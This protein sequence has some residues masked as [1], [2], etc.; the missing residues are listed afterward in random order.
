MVYTTELREH[1]PPIF[2]QKRKPPR[3]RNSMKKGKKAKWR[4]LFDS[5]LRSKASSVLK[6]TPPTFTKSIFK[7]S[8][9]TQLSTN[10]IENLKSQSI[11]SISNIKSI[12][13]I[14]NSQRLSYENSQFLRKESFHLPSIKNTFKLFPNEKTEIFLSGNKKKILPRQEYYKLEKF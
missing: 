8:R 7:T 1:L 9:L 5:E 2:G 10:L 6:S 4:I 13:S 3:K 12:H 11:R 14:N